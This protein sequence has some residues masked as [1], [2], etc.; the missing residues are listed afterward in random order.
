MVIQSPLQGIANGNRRVVVIPHL[1]ANLAQKALSSKIT[2]THVTPLFFGHWLIL[3]AIPKYINLWK[4]DP[5]CRRLLYHA[6]YGH[7]NQAVEAVA[8]HFQANEQMEQYEKPAVQAY[9]TIL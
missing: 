1:Y 4:Q 9:A 8:Y 2:A 6:T 5:V 7:P 3:Y